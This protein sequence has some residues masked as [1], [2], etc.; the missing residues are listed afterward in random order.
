MANRIYVGNLPFS[1]TD[2][3]LT[4][5]FSRAGKVDSV[6]IA[7][8]FYTGRSRGFAFV[9]MATANDA[10]HAI[11]EFHGTDFRGRQLTV[12]AARPR[13]GAGNRQ[14]ANGYGSGK[15]GFGSDYNS[16]YGKIWDGEPSRA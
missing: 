2:V 12:N 15:S 14:Y 10:E 9:Q 5:L 11:A 13:P 8:D 6:S 4:A 3:D 16:G 1:A 7:M